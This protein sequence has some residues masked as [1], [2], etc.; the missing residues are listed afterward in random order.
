[1][2]DIDWR[3]IGEN[4]K[5]YDRSLEET[6][7]FFTNRPL[8]PYVDS[9][10]FEESKLVSMR[11]FLPTI[12]KRLNQ[13][14]LLLEEI[15]SLMQLSL[16]AS[17]G[18]IEG[19]HFTLTESKHLEKLRADSE[20]MLRDRL[21]NLSMNDQ[22][23][24]WFPVVPNVLVEKWT[25]V[26]L[27]KIPLI[28]NIAVNKDGHFSIISLRHHIKVLDTAIE[29]TRSLPLYTEEHLMLNFLLHAKRIGV[30]LSNQ[31]YRDLYDFM[32]FLDLIPVH[33]LESHRSNTQKYV[34]ENYIK[35]LYRHNPWMNDIPPLP[36]KTAEDL[37]R[38][39]EE[40]KQKENNK[41]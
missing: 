13:S 41:Q 16:E 1:M 7:L 15:R 32:E 37:D 39:W 21:D 19:A 14:V 31:I 11:L 5:K 26:C 22:W 28:D 36:N 2:S 35:S 29:E 33:I 25:E 10:W 24:T 23:F 18:K 9:L 27:N 38:E 34:R 30:P 4:M 8:R 12:A 20:E 6:R 3:Y 40:E 17:T